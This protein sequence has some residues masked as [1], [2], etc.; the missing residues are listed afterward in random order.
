MIMEK[1]IMRCSALLLLIVFEIL[2][3]SDGLEIAKTGGGRFSFPSST[4]SSSRSSSSS[5]RSLS[6]GRFEESS[7]SSGKSSYFSSKIKRKAKKLFSSKKVEPKNGHSM[8][9]FGKVK[10]DLTKHPYSGNIWI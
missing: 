2:K 1:L 10:P 9:S 4:G 6:S 8:F 5:S 7:S 3:E